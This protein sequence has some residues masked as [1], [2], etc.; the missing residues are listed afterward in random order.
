MTKYIKKALAC[1]ANAKERDGDIPSLIKN[2][3]ILSLQVS[4]RFGTGK[5]G[6]IF[7]VFRVVCQ[8]CVDVIERMLRNKVEILR[9]DALGKFGNLRNFV[10]I[11]G[12]GANNLNR[13]IITDV[14]VNSFF[15]VLGLSRNG[16]RQ[17]PL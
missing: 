15:G 1:Q 6:V 8:V 2:S 7:A 9:D 16:R 13:L 11:M 10:N 17:I 3:P 5:R 4:C 12:S 14:S